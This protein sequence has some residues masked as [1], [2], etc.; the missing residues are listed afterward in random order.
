MTIR[1]PMRRRRYIL[2]L[3]EPDWRPRRR[4]P[5]LPPL[6]VGGANQPQF[7]HLG[8]VFHGVFLQLQRLPSIYNGFVKTICSFPQCSSSACSQ[9]CWACLSTVFKTERNQVEYYTY[10]KVALTDTLKTQEWWLAWFF[11]FSSFPCRCQF[12]SLPSVPFIIPL[13]FW[14]CQPVFTN[15]SQKRDLA[16]LGECIY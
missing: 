14:I 11:P 1:A 15:S 10:N 8:L 4:S 7:L 13:L 3:L 5:L 2:Q 6:C 9:S 16:Q 12:S